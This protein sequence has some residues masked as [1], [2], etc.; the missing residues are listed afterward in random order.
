MLLK[1]GTKAYSVLKMKCPHCHEGDFFVSHPYNLK[2]AGDVYPQ[3]EKCQGKFSLEPG[4]YYGALYLAYLLG[5][6]FF[7]VVFV[8]IYLIDPEAPVWLYGTAIGGG[9]LVLGPFLYALSKIMWINVFV[10]YKETE[11]VCKE[12]IQLTQTIKQK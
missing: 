9:M 10:N 11:S 7:I 1:K 5:I 6:F 8:V 2:K 3:C 4:F 12:N